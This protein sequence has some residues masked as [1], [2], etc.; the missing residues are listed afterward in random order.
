V[1]RILAAAIA[2]SA[3]ASCAGGGSVPQLP[4]PR[5]HS[6]ASYAV[7]P[8]VR[9]PVLPA[10]AMTA[11]TPATATGTLNWTQ[12]PGSAS[13]VAGARDGSLWA[14]SPGAPGTDKAIWHYSDGTWTNISG[15]ATQIAAAPNGTLYAINSGGATYA[16][17]AGAWTGLGG[18]AVGIAVATDNSIYVLSNDGLPDHAIWHYSGGWSQMPGSATSVDGAAD[19]GLYLTN[20]VG[21]I[22]HESPAGAIAQVPGAASA[23]APT[24]GGVFALGYPADPNGNSLYYYDESTSTWSTRPGAG[25]AASDASGHLYVL[26]ASGA[27][28]AAQSAPWTCDNA[29]FLSYQSQFAAHAIT[30]DQFVDLCGVVTSV[31]PEKHTTSGNHGYFYVQMPGG[32]DIEIICNLDAMGQ[33]GTSKP[34]G[35]WPWVGV[36]DYAYVQGRYYYD[37]ASSQ[38]VDWTEHDQS[39]SWPHYGYVVINGNFYD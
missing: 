33:N 4:T 25:I 12:I 21:A 13:V 36:G 11:T 1:K 8:M 19:G 28:F 15:A 22:Y 30:A 24:Y 10:S 7:A 31:L 26:G 35:T 16:Y 29:G 23:L 39:G 6:P 18:G 27:I 5:S 34:P 14:L 2:A 20:S 38:G 17:A 3:L 9:T 37:N 32:Y